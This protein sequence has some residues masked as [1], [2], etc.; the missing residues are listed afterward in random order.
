MTIVFHEVLS[1]SFNKIELLILEVINARSEVTTPREKLWL[2]GW[3]WL[4]ATG[5]S[6]CLPDWLPD[7]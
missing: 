2:A 3:L 1:I 7:G 5:V 4:S 6:G